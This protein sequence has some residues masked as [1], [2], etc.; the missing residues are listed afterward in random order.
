MSRQLIQICMIH[1]AHPNK[2]I[3]KSRISHALAQ[4]K[5]TEFYKVVREEDWSIL[6]N[7]LRA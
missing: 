1:P 7:F 2:G 4:T 5:V 6:V 3:R